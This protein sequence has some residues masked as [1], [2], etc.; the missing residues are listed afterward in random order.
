M[1]HWGGMKGVAPG[2]HRRGEV[3]QLWGKFGGQG[4]DWGVLCGTI[5]RGFA[6]EGSRA[7]LDAQVGKG[8]LPLAGI[9]PA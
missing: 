1:H 6:P 8:C 9:G 5:V 7:Q 3:V 2:V 4:A